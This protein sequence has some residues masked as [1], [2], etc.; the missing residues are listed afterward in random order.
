M[1]HPFQSADSI[2]IAVQSIGMTYSAKLVSDKLIG[3]LTQQGYT[4]PLDFSRGRIIVNRPQNPKPPFKYKVEN[5]TFS[6]PKANNTLGGTLTL[7]DNFSKSTPIVIMVSGSG[8]QNRDE[9][10]F[11]INLLQYSPITWQ[12]TG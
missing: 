2:S 12:I 9:E 4:F 1:L 11:I 8:L 10:I 5:V 6:N 7:P 3:K